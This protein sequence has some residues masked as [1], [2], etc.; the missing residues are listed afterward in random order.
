[1]SMGFRHFGNIA[2][3]SVISVL[4][5]SGLATLSTVV[6]TQVPWLAILLAAAV[7]LLII[8]KKKAKSA[9][10]KRK[11]LVSLSV[12]LGVFSLLIALLALFMPDFPLF[13]IGIPAVLSIYFD[14]FSGC[15]QA[16]I[17]SMLTMLYIAAAADT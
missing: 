8:A 5:Y 7:V 1:M 14:L 12:F 4:L 2:S 6:L 10:Q 15:L 13:Q 17:F 9:E 3:G 11:T 16:F